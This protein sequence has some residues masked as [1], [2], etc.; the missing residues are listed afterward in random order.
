MEFAFVLYLLTGIG[1]AQ[2]YG[3]D[4]WRKVGLLFVWPTFVGAKLAQWCQE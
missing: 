4:G 1:F 3:S 2:E